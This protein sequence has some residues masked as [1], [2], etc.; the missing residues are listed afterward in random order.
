MVGGRGKG[1]GEGR[2]E[3]PRRSLEDDLACEKKMVNCLRRENL[4]M[5]GFFL[6]G[7]CLPVPDLWAQ[8][9]VQASLDRGRC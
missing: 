8:L 2:P 5:S 3:R 4:G 1:Y 6:E 7:G 9:G